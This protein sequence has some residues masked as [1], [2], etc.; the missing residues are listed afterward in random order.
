MNLL[1]ER[2]NMPSKNSP[3]L[4]SLKE[5]KGPEEAPKPIL[6]PEKVKAPKPKVSR[7]SK[8]VYMEESRA[9]KFDLLVAIMKNE[10]EKKKG[11]DLLDEALDLLF[12]KYK[13]KL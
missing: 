9:R 5:L 7:I 10:D 3:N 8:G 2:R 6:D 12:E 4:R 11:P 1:M 13:G